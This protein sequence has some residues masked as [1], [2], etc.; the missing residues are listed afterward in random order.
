VNL[1]LVGVE[2]ST[3]RGA[4]MVKRGIFCV[5]VVARLMYRYF[6]LFQVWYGMCVRVLERGR[7]E[8]DGMRGGYKAGGVRWASS[9][10]VRFLRRDDHHLYLGTGYSSAQS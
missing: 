1:P 4:A 6:F 10:L 3:D 2:S 7:R 8:G 9:H 5:I